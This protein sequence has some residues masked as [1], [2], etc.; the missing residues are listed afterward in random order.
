MALW[1]NLGSEGDAFC[2]GEVLLLPLVV[3]RDYAWLGAP[4]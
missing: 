1:R 2:G 4:G 3:V